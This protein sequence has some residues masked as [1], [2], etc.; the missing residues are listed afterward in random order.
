VSL[1]KKPLKTDGKIGK[2]YHCRLI[3]LLAV[4]V[5]TGIYW[6]IQN[7]LTTEELAQHHLLKQE[8]LQLNRD[9]DKL[10]QQSQ[11]LATENNQQRQ[12]VALQQATETQLQSHLMELQ[13]QLLDLEKELLFYQSV[14][15]NISTEL[16]VREIQLRIDNNN[17]DLTLYRLVLTQ[18]KRITSPITGNII[19]SIKGWQ[20]GKEVSVAVAEIPFSLRYVRVLEGQL[21][22][23]YDLIPKQLQVS[24]KQKKKKTLSQVFDWQIQSSN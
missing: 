13:D 10:H 2:N 18:G 3:I 1:P 22:L 16:Q 4:A 17:P 15:Q 23:D 5:T 24:I 14:T 8:W 9:Y 11:L 21:S 20:A 7:Y 6:N 12:E 19:L